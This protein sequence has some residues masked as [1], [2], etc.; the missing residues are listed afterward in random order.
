MA[1]NRSAVAGAFL[2]LAVPKVRRMP[3]TVA[4]TI[5]SSVGVAKPASLWAYLMAA[6]RRPIVEALTLRPASCARKA[7]TVAG[8]AG[9]AFDPAWIRVHI[10]QHCSA[11]ALASDSQTVT[12]CVA[13]VGS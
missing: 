3:R 13:I 1:S 12:L 2:I 11:A 10:R 6:V 5:S 4:F 7:A 9:S 8:E